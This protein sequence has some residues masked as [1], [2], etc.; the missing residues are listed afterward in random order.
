MFIVES[1]PVAV[2]LCVITMICWGSWSNTQKFVSPHWR[3]E[4]YCWDFV[5]G[6]VLAAVLFAFTLGNFGSHGRSFIADI[7]QSE[8]EHLLSAML[9]GIIFNAAN[10]LFMASVS[11][12]GISVAFSVGAGLSLILG[13]I[14]NFSHSTVGNIFLLLLG[15]ALIVVAILLNASAYRK[16]FAGST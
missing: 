6:M 5:N 8:S 2:C 4:L 12:A 16:T 9:G 13:V 7:Q 15:V 11:F 14:V 3:F 10:I 1:Y